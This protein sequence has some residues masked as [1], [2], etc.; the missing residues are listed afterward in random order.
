MEYRKHV[1]E[2]RL[3]RLKKRLSEVNEAKEIEKLNHDKK[4]IEDRLNKI[5]PTSVSLPIETDVEKQ[6]VKVK[7]KRKVKKD[8][9]NE[10]IKN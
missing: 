2:E 9:N 10:E 7:R 8:S 6:D 5:E 3:E 4:K 1:L